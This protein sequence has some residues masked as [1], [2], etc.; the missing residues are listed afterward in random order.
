MC[1]CPKRRFPSDRRIQCIAP[2]PSNGE[3]V[4]TYDRD[5]VPDRL[6]RLK[7]L[8]HRMESKD[9]AVRAKAL[10]PGILRQR[11]C[12]FFFVFV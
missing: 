2:P 12:F 1:E 11:L 5:L 8:E 7:V 10:D 3:M 6:A 4:S 9:P